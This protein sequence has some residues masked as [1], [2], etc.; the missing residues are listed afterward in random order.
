M[1]VRAETCLK[2]SNALTATLTY[3]DMIV[4]IIRINAVY[5]L[6]GIPNQTPCT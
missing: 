2:I 3:K 1:K 4:H 5:V 6:L